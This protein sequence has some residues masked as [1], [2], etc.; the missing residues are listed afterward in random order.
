METFCYEDPS[1]WSPFTD[2]GSIAAGVGDEQ[3][4]PGLQETQVR[5][6]NAPVSTISMISLQMRV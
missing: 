3:A 1:Q 2:S 6:N 4:S 5:E